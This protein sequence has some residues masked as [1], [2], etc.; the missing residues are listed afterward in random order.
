M[1]R[2]DGKLHLDQSNFTVSSGSLLWG[3]IICLY[4]TT[5]HPNFTQN[6][7]NIPLK[8]EGGTIL[9]HRFSY[10]SAARNG[11]WKVR[12]YGERARIARYMADP[13]GPDRH[14][15]WILYHQDVNPRNALERVRALDGTGPGAV[16]NGNLHTDKV[17]RLSLS[18][19]F[20]Y[21]PQG[22]EADSLQDILY[23][24]RYDWSYHFREDL[25]P[26]FEQW[27]EPVTG[28]IPDTR[29]SGEFIKCN[30][31]N[32]GSLIA[33]DEAD[34]DLDLVAAYKRDCDSALDTNL[35][36]TT[37]E[38]FRKDGANFGT[39]LTMA[40]AEEDYGE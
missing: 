8:L 29:D 21:L 31:R 6:A 36:E 38:V 4:S 15:G 35:T 3:Q 25:E 33:I 26:K 5:S 14:V 11:P 37:I 22:Y 12:Q 17:R 13:D 34:F 18:F 32:G 7:D 30:V 10:R 1:R 28:A 20:L 19:R 27:A 9:Q 39:F 40:S 23:I 2:S 16:S 24:G